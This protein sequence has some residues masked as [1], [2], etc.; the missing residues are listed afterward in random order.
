MQF[1]FIVQILIGFTYATLALDTYGCTP[2]HYA[3]A[4]GNLDTIK[5]LVGLT[6]TPNAFSKIIVPPF[7]HYIE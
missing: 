3:A 7:E 2:I 4:N 1:T 5:F 6:D